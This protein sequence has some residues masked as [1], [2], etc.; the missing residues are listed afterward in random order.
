MVFD[1]DFKKSKEWMGQDSP[2]EIG[3]RD[4]DIGQIALN[5]TDLIKKAYYINA[6]PQP[7]V[8]RL[9]LLAVQ[10]FA[11]QEDIQGIINMVNIDRG[12]HDL[13]RN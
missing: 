4:T 2:Y 11:V 10:C 1:I 7:I 12:Q 5:L 9:E 8:A 3:G 6:V 13:E